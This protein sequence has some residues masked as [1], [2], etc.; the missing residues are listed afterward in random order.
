MKLVGL[1]MA[2]SP[3]AAALLRM[4]WCL[5]VEILEGYDWPYPR[6]VATVWILVVTAG[7][8]MAVFG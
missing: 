5:T 1:F 2:V 4:L 6:V 3:L 7:L 8:L